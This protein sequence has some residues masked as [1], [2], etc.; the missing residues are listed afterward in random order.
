MYCKKLALSN[1]GPFLMKGKV[2]VSI[3]VILIVIIMWKCCGVVFLA[4]GSTSTAAITS[5]TSPRCRNI[6]LET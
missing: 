6:A 2:V 1:G 3:I 4:S 5:D